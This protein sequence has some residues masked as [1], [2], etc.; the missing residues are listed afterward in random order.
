MVQHLFREVTRPFPSALRWVLIGLAVSLN[1]PAEPADAQVVVAPPSQDG[2]ADINRPFLDP[3]LNADEWVAKFEVESREVF[4]AREAIVRA[5]NLQPADRIADVGSGTGLFLQPLSRAVGPQGRVYAVDISP[6]LVAFVEGRV[7]DEKLTNVAVVRSTEDSTTLPPGS[8]NHV[9][10]CDAYHHFV[11]H[12][13]MLK[14]IHAALVPGG[15][16]TVVDFERIPGI[17][18]EWLLEHVRADKETVRREI[19]AVGLRYIGEVPIVNFKEN[20]LM[21]FEKPDVPPDK[22]APVLSV[23]G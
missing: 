17:S 3:S 2:V 14:S 19:E 18:R 6:K 8:V 23:P 1:A 15:W 9:F 11:Q 5:L 13:A 12:E 16:L 4:V 7:V 10:V 21:R 22:A 20:Y